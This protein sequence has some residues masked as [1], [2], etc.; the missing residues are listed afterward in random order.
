MS[1][2]VIWQIRHCH[3]LSFT[4]YTPSSV[5]GRDPTPAPGTSP[6]STPSATSVQTPALSPAPAP[7]PTPAS[8]PNVATTQPTASVHTGKTANPSDEISIT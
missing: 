1:S 6:T 8:T 4:G 5:A 7:A 3:S 2:S